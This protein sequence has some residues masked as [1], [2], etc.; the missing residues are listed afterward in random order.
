MAKQAANEPIHCNPSTAKTIL[1]FMI[2]AGE[3]VMLVGRPGIGKSDIVAQACE[4]TGFDLIITHPVVSDPVDY[5]GMP[6]IVDGEAEF[7]PFADLKQLIDT[8]K[9]TA[10]LIDDLG[11]SAPTVQAAVMQLV[12]ARQINGHKISDKIVFIAATNRR[13]DKA[14]VS[15][16]I[17]P[18]K[19]RFSTILH[20]KVSANEWVAWAA[21]QGLPSVLIAFTYWKGDAIWEKW[22]PTP[23]IVNQPIPRSMAA[24]GR[25]LNIEGI[26]EAE[27]KIAIA[28]AIGLG[29]ATELNGFIDLHDKLPNVDELLKDPQKAINSK[30]IPGPQDASVRYALTG[31]I[32]DRINKKTAKA[33]LEICHSMGNEYVILLGMMSRGRG[34]SITDY[35]ECNKWL[36]EN[37]SDIDIG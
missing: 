24:A 21:E 2:E 20:I 35:P 6:A 16:L 27:R 25:I 22:Q 36:S 13:E 33:A 19:S 18:L 23:D 10:V 5:K 31:A 26:P 34:T 1:S 11:Q 14:G 12:L 32:C 28:G 17:E 4:E 3:P 7:L 37:I 29:M 9:P 15:G 30:K 8:D